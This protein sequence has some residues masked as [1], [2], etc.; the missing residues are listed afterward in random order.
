[1][2]RIVLAAPRGFCAGVAYAIEVVDLALKIHG[3]PLYVRHAIVH[4][5]WVVRSFE[6]RGVVFVEDIDEI[7]EGM[8]VVFSAHGV[9]P[10]VRREADSRNLTVIDATCPL[11]T[12]VHNEARYYA[13][14]GYF[15]IYIGHEGH[16]EAEGTM[17]EA[18]DRMAL[19]ETPEDA[20]RLELPQ[21]DRLAVLTQ[22]TLSV[23]EVQR[24]LAV[25]QRRF[26]HLEL[27]KK[28]D[29]CYAT[30]NR[31]AAV[32]ALARECELILVVGSGTSSNSNRLRE[33]A[34][35]CGV[36]SHLLMTPDEVD[37][38]WASEYRSIGVTSGASTPEG[39][40]EDV[41]GALLDGRSNVSVTVLET[42]IEDVSFRPARSLIE[43]AMARS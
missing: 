42:V 41:V 32:R 34:E 23:D 36:R 26:P 37:P 19:V 2:E 28:E 21:A 35:A 27:P 1:M 6:A 4:N 20:E 17:G 14:Q 43:L 25:L 38:A 9:S 10:E 39:L 8:P 24:T 12:K 22:T 29:I 16:A 3:A 7:P 11:V 5:E 33:V 40:V 13:R 31:Q 15:M 30:T 18:P